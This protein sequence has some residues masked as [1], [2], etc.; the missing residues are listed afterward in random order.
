M[1][2][3][4]NSSRK[5]AAPG[6]FHLG[7]LYHWYLFLPFS[8]AYAIDLSLSQYSHTHRCSCGPLQSNNP[9]KKE[10]KRKGCNSTHKGK[11]RNKRGKNTDKKAPH[12]TTKDS[13]A[14]LKSWSSR[15][16]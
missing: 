13:L 15:T 7:I 5:A 11:V 8:L 9:P 3:S 12:L 16:R 10:N 4:S 14:E 1:E 2:P 6:H